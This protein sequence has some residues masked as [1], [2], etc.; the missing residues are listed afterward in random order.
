MGTGWTGGAQCILAVDVLLG[1]IRFFSV[2]SRRGAAIS[3][4]TTPLAVDSFQPTT[5]LLELATQFCL[6]QFFR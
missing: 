3:V 6:I 5:A 2:F 1:G 4:V